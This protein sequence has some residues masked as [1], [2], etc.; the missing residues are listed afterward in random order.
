MSNPFLC[1]FPG[2]LQVVP[3]THN[4]PIL[5]H[6]DNNKF[7]S[8]ITDPAFD[9][10]SAVC[11][12]VPA[13][14]ASFHHVRIAHASGPNTSNRSRRVCFIQ[15]CA[16]DAWP[17]IG[18]VG[19]EGYG[20]EGRVDWDRFCSTIVRGSPNLFPRMVNI[21]VSLPFPYDRVYDV[22]HEENSKAM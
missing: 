16:T 8:A 20:V 9:S 2:C 1:L 14:G 7:V 21:P 19:P 12:E 6:F 18:V 10:S 11:V 5:S 3:G 22:F 15:Y 13:G 4:G 17:L